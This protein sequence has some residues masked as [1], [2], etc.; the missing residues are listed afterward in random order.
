MR[1]VSVCLS[2]KH[3]QLYF[4]KFFNKY[5]EN[6][7]QNVVKSPLTTWQKASDY[8]ISETFFLLQVALFY[9]L[10]GFEY[11]HLHKIPFCVNLFASGR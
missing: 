8:C 10:D 11:C 6:E 1:T 9:N 2:P 4:V 7:T 5:V 3:I